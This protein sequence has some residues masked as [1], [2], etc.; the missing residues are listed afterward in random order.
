MTENVFNFIGVHD[1]HP[2]PPRVRARS[3]F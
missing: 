3:L 1:S 2:L